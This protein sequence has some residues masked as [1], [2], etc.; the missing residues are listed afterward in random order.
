SSRLVHFSGK[1]WNIAS[2]VATATTSTPSHISTS[3]PRLRRVGAT[4]R[5]GS[6][7]LASGTGD[8]LDGSGGGLRWRADGAARRPDGLASRADS[9]LDPA[10]RLAAGIAPRLAV[11]VSLGDGQRPDG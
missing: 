6:R 1:K 9:P 4:G 11:G 2:A 5:C 3:K 10:K 8:S 7:L